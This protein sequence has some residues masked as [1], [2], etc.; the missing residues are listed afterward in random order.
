MRAITATAVAL[1]GL[2]VSLVS[3]MR[4]GR[5]APE[6]DRSKSVV[7]YGPNVHVSREDHALPHAE[8]HLAISPRDGRTL[9]GAAIVYTHE[10]H[11]TTCKTFLSRD[12]GQQWTTTSFPERYTHGSADPQVAFGPTGTAYFLMLGAGVSNA[13][14]FYRSPDGGGTWE[15]ARRLKGADH[16]QV[17]VDMSGG[18]FNGRLYISAMHGIRSLRITHS[19]DD[20]RSFSEPI[21]VP[22][23]RNLWQLTLTPLVLRDGTL[24]VPYMAWDDA[25]GKSKATVTMVQLVTSSDGGL[26]FTA[27]LPVVGIPMVPWVQPTDLRQMIASDANPVLA[28]DAGTDRLYIAFADRRSGQ[29]RIWLSSSADRG[30]SWTPPIMV[31]PEAPAPS[32]QY[33]PILAVNREGAVGVGWFD[34]RDGN[35][36]R[37]ALYFTGSVDGGRSFPP[38]RRVSTALSA[39]LDDINLAPFPASEPKPGTE[40]SLRFRP[41]LGRWGNGGDYMGL[42]A[43]AA[44]LFHPLWTDSRDGVFQLWTTRIQ[45]VGDRG[46]SRASERSDQS[47]VPITDRISLIVDPPRYDLQ[48]QEALVPIRLLNTSGA[49][50][51]APLRVEV[52][53]TDQWTLLNGEKMSGS[54]TTTFDYSDALADFRTLGPGEVSEALLWRFRYSGLG[55]APAFSLVATGVVLTEPSLHTAA[56]QA[57]KQ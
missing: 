28:V 55:S 5:E 37:Y 4:V 34:T 21:P 48:T 46:A 39:P 26:T 40:L 20:G 30:R 9:L 56:R 49:T 1:L 23:P 7:R 57:P 53:K 32:V 11:G 2:S 10:I 29:R 6:P 25:G 8:P 12:G 16:P 13:T 41:C 31:D 19:S 50:I 33:Q 22:N 27:P 35:G 54:E 36:D 44:G 42:V 52:R 18:Q 51:G 24:V 15:P 17:V 3:F 43:D 47:P 38:A 14:L 45:V